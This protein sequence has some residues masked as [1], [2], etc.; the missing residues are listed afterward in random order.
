MQQQVAVHGLTHSKSE[1][2]G[3]FMSPTQKLGSI[4]VQV[5]HRLTTHGFAF[6][7]T[8]EPLAWFD[9]VIA[10]GLVDVKATSISKSLAESGVPAPNITVPKQ[11]G[12]VISSFGELMGREVM[13]L[14]HAGEEELL[15]S[16]SELELIATAAGE[17]PLAPVR[18]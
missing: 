4:G 10:C 7:V 17:G 18:R 6:N 13:E 5:R 3:L 15:S 2:T 9:Q 14:R 8:D 1:H 12:S 16:V 11:M